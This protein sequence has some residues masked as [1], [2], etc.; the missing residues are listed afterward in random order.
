MELTLEN[1]TGDRDSEQTKEPDP[2]LLRTFIA[3]GAKVGH[4]RIDGDHEVP[5]KGQE[6]KNLEGDE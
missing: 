5:N 4:E 1:S 6:E 3:R 2:R